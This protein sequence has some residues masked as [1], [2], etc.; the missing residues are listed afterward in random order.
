MNNNYFNHLLIMN[1]RLAFV[2]KRLLTTL[3]LVFSLFTTYGANRTASV[4]GPWS[5]MT[6]WGAAVPVAGDN[7]RINGGV[8]VTVD[9]SNA[10]CTDLR[11]GFTGG[12]G[13]LTF[14]SGSKVTT[15]GTFNIG[16]SGTANIDMTN[17]GT[18]VI[19]GGN[20]TI[21]NGGT[22]TPGTGTVSYGATAT[23]PTTFFTTYNNL[24][25]TAG[26]ITVGANRTVNGNL[27]ISGGTLSFGSAIILTLGGNF[28]QT[29][30]AG[31][32]TPSGTNGTIAFNKTGSQTYSVA[33]FTN[34]SWIQ[35]SI[36]ATSTLQLLTNLNVDGTT[37]FPSLLT[38]NGI[39]DAGAFVC[40]NTG[41]SGC[42]FTLA[43]GA[44]II[45]KNTAG[46][47]SGTSGTVSTTFATAR[48]FNAAADYTFNGTSTQ[49]TSTAMPAAFTSGGSLT[50]NNT[51][52]VTLS[53]A[54]AFG[55]G[56]NLNLTL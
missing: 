23:L 47:V 17:G 31:T 3:I 20:P 21:A 36:A 10:V 35:Y 52:G 4:T 42:T 30:T 5:S 14:N 19:T 8:T 54:T 6:T 55:T 24:T 15:S 7:V 16:Q 46:L 2:S 27:L 13:G 39:L 50:I 11:V 32:D 43:A 49:V 29:G 25:V 18:L 48:N 37:G 44:G 9:I 45:T 12:V 56:T 51:A 33:S 26:T 34:F 41:G 22:W 38:V 40:G 53:Q 28:T 1:H